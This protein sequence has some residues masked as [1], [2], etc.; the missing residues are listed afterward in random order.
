M[1]SENQPE[2]LLPDVIKAAHQAQLGE[3]GGSP[4]IRDEGAL[5][6]AL[7][8]PETLFTY[9]TPTLFELASAYASG[10]VRNHPFVD[11]NKRTGFLAAFIFLRVNG[12]LLQAA[13]AE[14]GVMT[15]GLPAAKFMKQATAS[16]SRTTPSKLR[17][18][19]EAKAKSHELFINFNL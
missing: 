7:A 12:Y 16:G 10:I 17:P 11:G 18:K 6:S 8:R 15:L 19:A 4:G 2:W 1:T 3:H 14:A 9:S 13:E 5:L